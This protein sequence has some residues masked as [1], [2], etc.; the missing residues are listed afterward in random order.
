MPAKGEKVYVLE[1]RN[2]L[3][4]SLLVSFAVIFGVFCIL[5]YQS[6]SKSILATIHSNE[7][8]A[9][10]LAKLI[11]EHQRAAVGVLRLYADQPVFVDTVKR[12]DFGGALKHLIDLVKNNPEMDWP[13]ISNPDSTVWV[14]HPVDRQAWNKDFSFRDWY[15]GVSKEWKPYT[16]S[17]YKLVVGEKDLAVAISV[18]VF[19]EQD[20]VIGILS[21]AQSTAFFQKTIGEIG[22]NL[23][24]KVTLID[25]EGHIVY[26]NAFPYTKDV[27]AYPALGF[28]ER[29]VKGEKGDIEV[30]DTAN[31]DRVKYV[32]F[33]PVEGIGWSIIVEKARSEVFRSEIPYLAMIC[34]IALLLF[35]L[36]ALFLVHLR[37]RHRQMKDLQ[38]LN[39]ELDGRVR[40]RTAELKAGN[41]ALRVRE[42]RLG[43]VLEAA[44]MVTW[45]WDIPNGFI[46]YSDNLQTIVRGAA[47]EPYSSLDALMPRIHPE[48]RGRLAQALDR[49]SASTA[50]TCWTEPIAGFWG[51]GSS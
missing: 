27:I 25:Q 44:G 28:V 30:H 45:E 37:Q 23:G 34:V 46:R 42:T 51:K 21:S 49:T 29:A 41:E 31:Q 38:K 26:S 12:R 16:S 18:P 8:K 48:D 9:T 11:L 32:S 10:L 43:M 20:R 35:G 15:K 13:F 4:W 47:V 22:L 36:C 40:E 14:N 19:D 3:A 2:A 1:R 6:Y 24:T 39:E 5:A 33:A 7:T 17:V 50:F